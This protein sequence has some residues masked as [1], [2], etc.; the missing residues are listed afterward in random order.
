MLGPAERP[1]WPW[2]H[3]T[4]E[5]RNQGF[6]ISLRQDLPHYNQKDEHMGGQ[7]RRPQENLL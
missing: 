2:I 7:I 1:L 4:E 3:D 5:Y 6:L